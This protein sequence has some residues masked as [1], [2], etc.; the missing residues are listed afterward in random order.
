VKPLL[1]IVAVGIAALG[2]ALTAFGEQ[3][4]SPGAILLG[5]LIV[6]AAVALGARA[7]RRSA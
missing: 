6:L 5:V 1:V 3:D 4:D 7:A 2:V